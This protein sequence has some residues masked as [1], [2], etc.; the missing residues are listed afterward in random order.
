VTNGGATISD[1]AVQ[2]S[3]NSGATWLNANDGLSAATTA[4]VRGLTNGTHYVFRVAAVNSVGTGS[5][6]SRSAAVM[7]VVQVVFNV[8]SNTVNSDVTTHVGAVQLV[9]RGAGSL[10]LTQS[11][12]HVGGTVLEAGILTIQ[13]ASALGSGPLTVR[14]GATL[15]IDL[16]DTAIPVSSLTVDAGGRIDFGYGR[17]TIPY[18]ASS[19]STVRD[20]L[21]QGHAANWSVP[22]GLGTSK[23]ATLPGSSLGYVLDGSGGV[24]FGFAATGDANLD[25]CVDVLDVASIL[26]AGRFNTGDT[27]TWSE[28]DFNYDGV[29][30]ILDLAGF[31]SSQLVDAG[32]YLPSEPLQG[33]AYDDSL[34][35]NDIAFLAFGLDSAVT[36]SDAKK[37]KLRF[38]SA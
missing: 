19:W 26:D 25:G 27:A 13:N 1:Y 12:S 3:S 16:L 5:F 15:V 18:D 36:D 29:V 9:K 4:W 7:P 35:A 6:S 37:N 22:K 20:L 10:V 38:A 21:I 17:M 34:S 23:A 8:A 24:T 33:K 28:G 14:A 30:D 11:N 32:R 2:Y 31:L